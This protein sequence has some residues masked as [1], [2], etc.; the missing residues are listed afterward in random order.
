L[1]LLVLDNHFGEGV[2]TNPSIVLNWPSLLLMPLLYLSMSLV[3]QT[4][5]L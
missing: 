3:L 2:E 4:P 1:L 5:R